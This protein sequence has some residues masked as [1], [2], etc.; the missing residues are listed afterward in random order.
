LSKQVLEDR[1]FDRYRDEVEFTY[2]ECIHTGEFF[3]GEFNSH[4]LDIWKA[5]K[6]DGLA[7]EDFQDI[8]EEV[9][10]KYVDLIYYPFSV[11]IAA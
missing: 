4:L 8:V 2:S 3:A 1:M 5:A 10:T 7:E 6:I 9:V 11:A